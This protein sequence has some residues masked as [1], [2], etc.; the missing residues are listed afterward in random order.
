MVRVL[1]GGN[2]KKSPPASELDFSLLCTNELL[3]VRYVLSHLPHC[4]PHHYRYRRLPRHRR[5][6]QR[7][8]YHPPRRRP[9]RRRT[10]YQDIYPYTDDYMDIYLVADLAT[11]LAAALAATDL[12]QDFGTIALATLRRPHHWCRS[13]H[14]IN[15]PPMMSTVARSAVTSMVVRLVATSCR[16]GCRHR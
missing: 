2:K 9:G 1:Q 11:D 15:M 8:R 13:R 10:R 5:C 7:S 14:A 16:N 6:Y 3:P 4:R 12:V